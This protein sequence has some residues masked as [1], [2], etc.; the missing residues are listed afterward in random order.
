MLRKFNIKQQAAIVAYCCVNG[1]FNTTNGCK[2]KPTIP[3]EPDL[4]Y[5]I[6]MHSNQPQRVSYGSNTIWWYRFALINSV[7]CFNRHSS[8]QKGGKELGEQSYS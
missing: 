7:I 5:Y 1:Q 2:I 6:I 3:L 4:R 8:T